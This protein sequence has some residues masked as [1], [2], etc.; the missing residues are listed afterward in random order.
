MPHTFSLSFLEVFRD[1]AIF[2]DEQLD[3]LITALRWHCPNNN[4]LIPT[5][6]EPT[7]WVSLDL[8]NNKDGK[9][10][11]KEWES[12]HERDRHPTTKLQS[13]RHKKRE[14]RNSPHTN[15]H[16]HQTRIGRQ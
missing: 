2:R 16:R 8:Q 14:Y 12:L 5:N 9:K 7:Y 6:L 1:T 3:K 11:K 13:T 15:T 10:K 4:L